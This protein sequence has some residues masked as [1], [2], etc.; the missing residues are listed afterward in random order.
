MLLH[1]NLEANQKGPDQHEHSL[2]YSSSLRLLYN[3]MSM[4]VVFIM[5]LDQQICITLCIKLEH[6]SAKT[7]RKI[8]N[9]FGKESMN[10]TQ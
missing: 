7:I 2:D 8:K 9:A 1:C 10:D 3:H 5:C 4:I 6:L